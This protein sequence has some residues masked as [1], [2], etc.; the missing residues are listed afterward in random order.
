MAEDMG[1]LFFEINCVD[2]MQ[3]TNC[4]LKIVEYFI[5]KDKYQ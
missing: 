2:R 1:A 3:V 4:F 5:S